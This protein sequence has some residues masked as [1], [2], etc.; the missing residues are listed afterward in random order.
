MHSFLIHSLHLISFA[1]YGSN[2]T[3]LSSIRLYTKNV[4]PYNSLL[5]RHPTVPR[6]QYN[7]KKVHL[8]PRISSFLDT[9][10]FS[11]ARILLYKI[12]TQQS[13]LTL[14]SVSPSHII[15]YQGIYIH[16]PCL[17]ALESNAFS[18]FKLRPGNRGVYLFVCLSSFFHFWLA[19]TL[20]HSFPTLAHTQAV[21]H[22]TANEILLKPCCHY[23]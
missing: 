14:S 17:I 13:N 1:S 20:P 8:S 19:I 3:T 12:R 9:P 23:A 2:G 22:G 7:W 11:N 16:S 6:T 21:L 18:L 4:Y 5:P 15:T 10:N